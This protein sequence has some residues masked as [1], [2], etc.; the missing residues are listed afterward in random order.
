LAI[1]NIGL[2]HGAYLTSIG[3]FRNAG[4]KR[5]W[6]YLWNANV[7]IGNITSKG[8]DLAAFLVLSNPNR[9]NWDISKLAMMR[10]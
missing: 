1:W 6:Q 2:L 3:Y 7:S 10:L 8:V 9:R 5:L 4:S